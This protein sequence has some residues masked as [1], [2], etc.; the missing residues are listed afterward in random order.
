MRYLA[1]NS[2][3]WKSRKGAVG[4]SLIELLIVVAIILILAAIAIPN[5]MRSRIAANESATVQNMRSIAT[6]EYGYQNLYGIGYSATLAD[7]GGAGT[8]PTAANLIDNVLASGTKS[9][10]VVGYAPTS[11]DANGSPLGFTVNTT[12]LVPNSTGTRYF[13]VDQTGVIH[14]KVGGPATV[15]D[16]NL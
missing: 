8:G 14:W 13:Y 15:T 11:P 9:G 7:L 6:A 10:Y 3:E 5:F 1:A 16:P 2:K 12:P 4:F